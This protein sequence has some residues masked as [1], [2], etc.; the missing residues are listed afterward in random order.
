MK[1]YLD[2]C[3]TSPESPAKQALGQL[4]KGCHLVIHNATLLTDENIALCTANQ[5]QQQKRSKPVLSISQGGIMTVR[6]GQLHMQS[7][8]NIN[9][10]VEEPSVV[11]SNTKAPQRCSICGSYEHTA[12]TCAQRH[13]TN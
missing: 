12:H 7:C 5:K 2:R 4:I 6:E 8:Q 13:S 1:E 11:Q 3:T 10:P 9:I